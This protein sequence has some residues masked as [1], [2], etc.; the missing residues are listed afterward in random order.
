[1][2][3]DHYSDIDQAKYDLVHDYH[4]GPKKLAAMVRMNLGTLYN[5]VNPTVDTHHLTVD[6]AIALQLAANTTSLIE[7]EARALGGVFLR[8][9]LDLACIGDLELLNA[10][11]AWHVDTGE[12]AAAIEQALSDGKLSRDELLKIKK[13]MFQDFQRELELLQRLEVICD[14]Q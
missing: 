4:D 5:K 1:M 13:E 9:P 6:E 2:P 3:F 7:A 12:T 10:W 8:I 11:A 14:E